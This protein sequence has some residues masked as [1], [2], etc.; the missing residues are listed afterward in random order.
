MASVCKVYAT[1]MR[2]IELYAKDEGRKSTVTGGNG[3]QAVPIFSDTRATRAEINVLHAAQKL[4]AI[5][6]T[7]DRLIDVIISCQNALEPGLKNAWP[8]ATIQPRQ[9]RISM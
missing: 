9:Q 2:F 6:A 8:W 7:T 1:N 4:D 5:H 3:K